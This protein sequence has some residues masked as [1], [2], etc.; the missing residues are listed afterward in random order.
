MV[1]KAAR[2]GV[3]LLAAISAPTALAVST[4]DQA[5]LCLVGFARGAD[6]VAYSHADRLIT[7]TP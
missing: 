3:G 2:A 6:W 5:G 4:A 1:Q 7:H